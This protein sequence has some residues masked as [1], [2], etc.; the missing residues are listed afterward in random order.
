MKKTILALLATGMMLFTG[1][2]STQESM[3]QDMRAQMEEG[4]SDDKKKMTD[5]EQQRESG[6]KYD[7][8]E[9]NKLNN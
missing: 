8:K 4:V 6:E 7:A 5:V 2:A 3:T 1:C 9:M